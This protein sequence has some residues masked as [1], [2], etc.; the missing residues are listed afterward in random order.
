MLKVTL[1]GYILV[2]AA[3]LNAVKQA[4]VTHQRL[5]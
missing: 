4:L 1:K 3:D 5:T 2:P